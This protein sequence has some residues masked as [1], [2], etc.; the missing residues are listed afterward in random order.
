MEKR[1]EIRRATEN[2]IALIAA[3]GRKT[4]E[5]TFNDTNTEEDMRKYISENFTEEKIAKEISGSESIFLIALHDGTAAAYMKLNTG[6]AQTEKQGDALEIQRLYVADSKK[7]MGIG[8]R[9]IASAEE[10]A[11]VRGLC[12]IWLGVWEHNEPALAFY[13]KCGFRVF[14]SHDFVLGTD[15]QTDML[16]E[17]NI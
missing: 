7:G 10:I 2:D 5:E 4:F 8:R 13:K 9:M 15:R 14:S 12:R 6:S 1:I 11:R 16:M 17:K 3:I